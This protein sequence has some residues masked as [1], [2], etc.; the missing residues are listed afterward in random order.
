MPL[1]ILRKLVIRV[2]FQLRQRTQIFLAQLIF[3][4]IFSRFLIQTLIWRWIYELIGKSIRL[5]LFTI[6]FAESVWVA[7]MARLNRRLLFH[8]E[9]CVSFY[10]A[11]PKLQNSFLF[12]AHEVEFFWIKL[13]VATFCVFVNSFAPIFHFEEIN[14]GDL[15]MFCVDFRELVVWIEPPFMRFRHLYFGP[16]A[17]QIKIDESLRLFEL[18]WGHEA[19]VWHSIKISRFRNLLGSFGQSGLSWVD[20]INFIH[21]SL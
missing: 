1:I 4:T 17:L 16:F 18:W 19:A 10:H 11:P 6:F 12:S 14:L 8:D 20:L 3:A 9:F 5:V 15:L 13:W 7:A 2:V 21:N